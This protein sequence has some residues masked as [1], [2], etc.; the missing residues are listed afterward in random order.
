LAEKASDGNASD[1]E[2]LDGKA[3]EAA[4]QEEEG[5][6]QAEAGGAKEGAA[7]ASIALGRAGQSALAERSQSED[8]PLPEDGPQSEDGPLPEDGSKAS[9]LGGEQEAG[10]LRLRTSESRILFGGRVVVTLVE[11]DS[12]ER[13]SLV[14]VHYLESDRRESSLL[15]PG[16]SLVLKDSGQD[17][18]LLLESVK[19]S[20]VALS[21][22]RPSQGP[23]S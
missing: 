12:A 1:K 9:A 16:D 17:Y 6:G 10:K 18:R 11:L 15:R 5:R 13:E 3:L 21:I 2:S 14:R 23:A 7:D 4:A 22:F 19:G 8:G 20:Q